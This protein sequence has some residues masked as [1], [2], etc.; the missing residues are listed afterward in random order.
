MR[1]TEANNTRVFMV[2][3][4]ATKRQIQQAGKKLPDTDG[5]RSA[6]RSA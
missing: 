5:P 1:K 2:G 6:P 3:V 4:K